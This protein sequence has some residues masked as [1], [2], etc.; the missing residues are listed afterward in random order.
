M[1]ELEKQAAVDQ[2]THPAMVLLTSRAEFF[3]QHGTID[4]TWRRR[5]GK[6]FGPYYRLR[7]REGGSSRSVYLGPAGPL[8]AHVRDILHTLQA[9]L[10]Q[11]R[12]M[13]QLQ[14]QVRDALRLD[15]RCV[16][17]Q[18]RS[19]GLRLK[20]F[21]VRGWR[22]SPIRAITRGTAPISAGT[23]PIFA[24]A[25][26]GLSPFASPRAGSLP[27]SMRIKPFRLPRVRQP[28]LAPKGRAAKW[29]RDNRL[30]KTPEFPQ[31]R[32]QTVFNAR[33]PASFNPR[34]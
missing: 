23:A 10:R 11:H 29:F 12:A 14:R 16:D 17:A 5:N 30:Q 19:L 2:R 15:R 4:A 6:T 13:L 20:G 34:L 32:L 27:A 25:K 28:Q 31:N 1:S 18:L 9:P 22:T 33:N 8:V 3:A 7:Y 21:E 26:M 24:P